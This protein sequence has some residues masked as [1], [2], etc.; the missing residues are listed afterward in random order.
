MFASE[1]RRI[2]VAFLQ[3]DEACAPREPAAHRL[4]HDEI[5][6]LEAPVALRLVEGQRD[7]GSRGVGMPVYRD[8]DLLE[9]QTKL[10][11]RRFEY[12]QVGLMRHHP[13]DVAGRIA[14]RQ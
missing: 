9:R 4:E 10:L 11:G 13:I 7:G 3:A 1:T 8:D 2:S 6:R 12:P 14:A 5:A